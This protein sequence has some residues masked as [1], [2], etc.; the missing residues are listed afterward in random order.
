MH[1]VLVAAGQGAFS[2]DLLVMFGLVS[3]TLAAFFIVGQLDFKRMLAY[4]SVEHVGILA[5]GVGLG[6]VAGVG[7]MLHAVNHSLTKGALFMVAG[8]ILAAYRTKSTREVRGVVSVLPVTGALWVAGFLA[9]T[10]TPPFGVFQSELMILKGAVDAGRLWVAALYLLLLGVVFVG[11]ARI[12]I[13]M[14]YGH[15]AGLKGL[16][17]TGGW[18]ATTGGRREARWSIVPPALLGAAVLGLGLY[19]PPVLRDL[20]EAAAAALGAKG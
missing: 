9:I 3:M 16:K 12:V 18:S 10:G 6:G 1:G 17:E 2:Q 8:N 14:A 13:R 20:I 19:V 5:L 11:M 4:S 15:P 7:S